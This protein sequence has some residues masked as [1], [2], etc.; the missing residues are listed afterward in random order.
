MDG[1]KLIANGIALEKKILKKPNETGKSSRKRSTT[2]NVTNISKSADSDI[3]I[4]ATAGKGKKRS[5][6]VEESSADRT[7]ENTNNEKESEE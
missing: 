4:D 7:E 2:H 3:V 6:E 5:T 1:V